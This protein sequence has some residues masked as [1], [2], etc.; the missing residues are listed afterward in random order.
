MNP[1]E[2]LTV[3]LIGRGRIGSAV[4][5]GLRALPRY[6]V[7]AILGRD[8]NELPPAQLTI[9]AAG[10]DALRAFGEQALAHGDLWTVGASALT[11]ANLRA[12]LT[13]LATKTGHTAHLFTGWI[14]GP[15]L[16]PPNLAAQLFVRQTAP[17]IADRPGL[18]FRGPLADAAQ[19]FP[20]HLNSATAAALTGPGIEATRVTLVSSPDQGLHQISARFRMPG[21]TIRTRVRFDGSGP[22]PVAAAILAA[23]A[24]RSQSIRLVH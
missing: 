12:Q 21:Q 17:N 22:H 24:R 15:T 2:P 16:C 1:S 14:C 9:D 8:A 6:E 23:L 19:R 4:A 10:P 3:A 5:E 11:D 20:E 18:L 13:H 7:V